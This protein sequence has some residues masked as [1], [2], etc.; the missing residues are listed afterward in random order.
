MLKQMNFEFFDAPIMMDAFLIGQN[1]MILIGLCASS[2]VLECIG[3]VCIH[4]WALLL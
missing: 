3:L 4:L 1:V 2:L